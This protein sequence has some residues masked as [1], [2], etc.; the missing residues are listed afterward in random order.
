MGGQFDI[1]LNQNTTVIENDNVTS[2]SRI[3]L[4]RRFFETPTEE[5]GVYVS[6]VVPGVSFTVSHSSG[7]ELPFNY[8]II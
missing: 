8:I 7:V 3:V 2:A 6:N 1:A 5:R 4:V